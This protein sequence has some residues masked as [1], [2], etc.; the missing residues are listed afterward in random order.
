M[1]FALPNMK[2]VLSQTPFYDTVEYAAI[3]DYTCEET[4]EGCEESVG[5]MARDIARCLKWGTKEHCT[6][7]LEC[8]KAREFKFAYECAVHK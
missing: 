5:D 2:D 6:V 3:D 8:F 1:D 4:C 7:C